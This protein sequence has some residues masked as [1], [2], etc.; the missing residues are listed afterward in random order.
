MVGEYFPWSVNDTYCHSIECHT[1]ML[2]IREYALDKRSNEDNFSIIDVEK[3][4]KECLE[5]SS[6]SNKN[7]KHE[8]SFRGF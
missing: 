3:K 1:S 2:G 6:T 4:Y 7:K 5:K 8:T